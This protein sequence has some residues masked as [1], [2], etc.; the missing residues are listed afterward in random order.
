MI[1]D[2]HSVRCYT[3]CAWRIQQVLVYMWRALKQRR[4]HLSRCH[5]NLVNSTASEI[6]AVI[7]EK[8]KKLS[9]TTRA[10]V[11]EVSISICPSI[12]R[13]HDHNHQSRKDA[14]FANVAEALYTIAIVP[15]TGPNIQNGERTASAKDTSKRI[16]HSAAQSSMGTWLHNLGPQYHHRN[17][18]IQAENPT[19]DCKT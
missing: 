1:L 13:L 7:P 8:A 10:H 12:C 2:H 19:R 5:P 18:M 16:R 6:S 17:P 4:I 9:L 15:T 11:H 14:P 3:K